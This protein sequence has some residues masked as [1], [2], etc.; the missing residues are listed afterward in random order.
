MDSSTQGTDPPPEHAGITDLPSGG[1]TGTPNMKKISLYRRFAYLLGVWAV[2]ILGMFF[3]EIGFRMFAEP[4]GLLDVMVRDHHQSMFN[5]IEGEQVFEADTLLA[6]RFKPSLNHVY[7]DYTNF[8][9]GP[10]GLRTW[11]GSFPDRRD[12]L[13]LNI[14]CVGD[15][16]TFGYRVPVAFPK[17][18]DD[19]NPDSRPF[20]QR[21]EEM[22][23]DELTDRDVRVIPMAV[24]G[25]STHQGLAWVRRDLGRYR[26]DIVCIC[27]GW[28]DTD[29][30][31]QPDCSTLPMNF[32]A[33]F[34][35]QLKQK[36]HAFRN[37]THRWTMD[38]PDAGN[39]PVAIPAEW[40][41]RVSRDEYVENILDMAVEIRELGAK[42]LV[43]A[44]VYR[45]RKKDPGHASRIGDCRRDL[46][47]KTR[48]AFVPCL[49]IPEL[50]EES[51]DTN[52]GLF[53]EVIHP[54]ERGHFLMANRVYRE[55][56]GQGWLTDFDPA[57]Q[58]D[59]D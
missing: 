27:F 21:L 19:F 42:P 25:Y 38:D 1:M 5:G 15:S 31:E 36:S 32:G 7:W 48:D 43:I 28:N 51:G 53:G 17:D 40:V 52:Q 41:P 56:T 18:P 37:L 58:V 35:R 49:V 47:E 46:V 59:P 4:V 24:P 22:L 50:T 6:W 29:L 16:V 10:D 12:R 33:R 26:P 57:H 13:P 9:T 54:N 3:V 23:R 55:I 45:D 30:R 20:P 14:V 2:F 11:D 34:Q 39:E 44:P 8:S